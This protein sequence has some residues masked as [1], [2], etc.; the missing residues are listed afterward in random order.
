MKIN[1]TQAT[2]IQSFFMQEMHD[3]VM[4]RNRCNRKGLEK[5]QH[6]IAIGYCAASEFTNDERMA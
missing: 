4:F 6:F 2:A 1:P 3:L 5:V